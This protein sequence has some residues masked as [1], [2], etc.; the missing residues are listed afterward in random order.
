MQRFVLTVA[1][2]VLLAGI[3]GCG[4]TELRNE[5]E[6]LRTAL[7]QLQ[8]DKEMLEAQNRK[9]VGERDDYNQKLAQARKDADAYKAEA[10]RLKAQSVRL[11]QDKK[12]LRKLADD[13]KLLVD[14]VSRDGRDYIVMKSDII[15]EAGK[16]ELTA[17]AKEGLAVIAEYLL[18][19][20]QLNVRVDGHTDGQP[21]K[22]SAWDDNYHLSCA[23]ALS[24]R[25]YLVEKGVD[26][27]RLHVA[28][29][30]PN[31]PLVE[32][33]TPE[34]NMAENRRV[35]ILILP[36]SAGAVTDIPSGL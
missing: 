11:E 19:H 30:G 24:V 27:S 34:V 21:I 31:V 22:V 4:L 26:T 12:A 25:K 1:L 14:L 5:N 3:T 16:N 18:Q 23:R 9:L 36:D 13:L 15:F 17:E 6:S 10:E 29:F 20:K 35:E 7:G 33:E 2:G 28:G 8:R 32:P